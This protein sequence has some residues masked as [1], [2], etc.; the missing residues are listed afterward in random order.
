MDDSLIIKPYAVTLDCIEPLALVQFYAALL[1]W[2]TGCADDGEYAWT[3]PPGTKQG[4]YPCI[5]AQRNTD[6]IPPVWPEEPERQQ[7]M[8][9]L[10]FAVTDLDKAVKHAVRCGA[11]VAPDQFSEHWTVMLD[12]A[13]HPFCLCIIPQVFAAE[14]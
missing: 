14:S 8:A 9:H 12:P 4:D 5:T 6:Y 7:Q 10:D 1:S 13:G 2:E 11:T 3:Y